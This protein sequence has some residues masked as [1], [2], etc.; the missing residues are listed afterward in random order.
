MLLNILCSKSKE[1]S[2]TKLPESNWNGAYAAKCKAVGRGGARNNW[3]QIRDGT[4]VIP[5]IL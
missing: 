1:S 5:Q 4:T 3:G 2:S